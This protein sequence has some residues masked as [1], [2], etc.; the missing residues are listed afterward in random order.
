MDA[1]AW[2]R[3]IGE[4][5]YDQFPRNKMEGLAAHY[6][7]LLRKRLSGRVEEPNDD[8]ELDFD[9]DTN[10]EVITLALY[11]ELHEEALDA[12]ERCSIRTLGIHSDNFLIS[13]EP[14]VQSG[15]STVAEVNAGF[16]LFGKACGLR[17]GELPALAI[18]SVC[19]YSLPMASS[20]ISGCRFQKITIHFSDDDGILAMNPAEHESVLLLLPHLRASLQSST[21]LQEIALFGLTEAAFGEICSAFPT[22]TSL[23]KCRLAGTHYT[24]PLAISSENAGIMRDV[25]LMPWLN[26]VYLDS[27]AFTSHEAAWI[28]LDAVGRSHHKSFSMTYKTFPDGMEVAFLEALLRTT[29]ELH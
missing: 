27:I 3:L 9:N 17:F 24:R 15:I 18:S 16:E 11:H 1:E 2:H 10:H 4:D 22:M 6:A 29:I 20:M 8:Y 21:T 19:L 26:E 13:L 23:T 25:V 12:I 14:V 5:I 7:D 28:V